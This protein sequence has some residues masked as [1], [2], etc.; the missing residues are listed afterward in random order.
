MIMGGVVLLGSVTSGAGIAAPLFLGPFLVFIAGIR[1]TIHGVVGV[2]LMAMVA[3]MMSAAVMV[4]MLMLRLALLPMLG[5][6]TGARGSLRCQGS[7]EDER[8][9]ADNRLHFNSPKRVK[10]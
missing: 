6:W 4:L 10:L 1:V 7:G 9:R 8:D 3:L 2:F 5:M